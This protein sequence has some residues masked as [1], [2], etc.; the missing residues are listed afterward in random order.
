MAASLMCCGVAK[1]GSPAPKVDHVDALA[2]QLVGLGHDRHG[3]GGLDAIDA[4]GQLDRRGDCGRGWSHAF[5]LALDFRLSDFSLLPAA[6]S[7]SL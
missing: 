6:N 3:G 4:F 2:A 1:C 7:A 5:F